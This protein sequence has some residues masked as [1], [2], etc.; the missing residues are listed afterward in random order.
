MT[1]IRQLP[2]PAAL[3]TAVGSSRMTGSQ[4]ML[5]VGLGAQYDASPSVKLG[6]VVRTPGIQILPAGTYA[7]DGLV[8]SG[9]AFRQYSFLDSET[10]SFRYKLPVEA[11][12]AAAWISRNVELET[13]LKW[14]SAVSPYAGFSSP[15]NVLVAA[16][17]GDGTPVVITSAPFLERTFE[18]RSTWNASLGGRV[19]LDGKK[20]W[21][22]HTGFATD[23][24]PVGSA[25]NFFSQVDLYSA[26]VGI[27]G[28]AFHLAGSLGLTYQFGSSD[29]KTI[30]ILGGG[31]VTQSKFKI[32]NFGILYPASYRF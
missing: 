2:T 12:V 4:G 25:D 9:G 31:Q 22:L 6:A 5:R 23:R 16:D 27:S 14:Q 20:V 32:R 11:A 19:A 28:E 18:L 30:P 8:E 3:D 21:K 26:T 15:K 29:E 17:P 24:P 13:D 10:M 1:S 7:A